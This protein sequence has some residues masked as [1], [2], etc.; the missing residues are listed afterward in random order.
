M[1]FMVKVQGIEIEFTSGL[2]AVSFCR[3]LNGLYDGIYYRSY[4]GACWKPM[5][6]WRFLERA[7]L[8]EQL[9]VAYNTI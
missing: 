1:R 2:E 5:N 3:T 6:G 4:R 9:M 8:A 7:D